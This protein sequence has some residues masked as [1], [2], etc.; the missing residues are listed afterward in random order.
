MFWRVIA[1]LKIRLNQIFD[2]TLAI[3]LPRTFRLIVATKSRMSDIRRVELV[4]GGQQAKDLAVRRRR[5]RRRVQEGGADEEVLSASA[6]APVTLNITKINEVAT[7]G[8]SNQVAPAPAPV[9]APIPAP[10]SMSASATMSAPM[11]ASLPASL[12][13]QN[14]GG[15][16]TRVILKSKA[17]RT[18]KVLLKKKDQ[19]SGAEAS[20]PK[21]KVARTKT[22]KIVLH[23]PV[24]RLNKTRHAIKEG[25]TIPLE[26]LRALL[27]EKKL[28]KPTSKAPEPILR[29]I[30]TDS[31]IVA[32]KTL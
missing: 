8:P 12:P 26:K 22:R 24:K 5:T 27:I 17:K 20:Q 23:A 16:A 15:S 6:S 30:Y 21:A 29:Q 18:T 2:K 14:A 1:Q 3:I 10:A 4:G 28:I 13:I 25:K 7:H 32:K 9:P 19:A 11:S 31:L